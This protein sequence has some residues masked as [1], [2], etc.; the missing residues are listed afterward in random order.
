MDNKFQRTALLLG[1]DGVEKLSK[2][3][4]AVFGLGGV[5]GYAVEALA[6]S[7]IGELD[8][9][10]C[11][12][13]SESNINRQIIATVKSIGQKKTDAAAERVLSINPNIKVRSHFIEFLPKTSENFEFKK[14]DYIIDAID[15]VTGKIELVLKAD[16]YGVPIISSM[17]TGNK[18]DPSAFKIADIYDTSVC[19][20]ARVM[21]RELKKRNIKALKVV[22]SEE[23]P[24][25]CPNAEP[26]NEFSRRPIPGSVSFVPPA[27][28]LIIAGE[29]IK[30][31][32][33]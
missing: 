2:K 10:D 16:E 31:L 32:I 14:Y 17:G 6:R 25:S 27:A 20:L 1:E 13:V 18:L 8:L 23:T 21:R 33:K 24:I 29:V 26:A 22:Y 30:D 19:P 7:G 28:G 9:I 11:D 15:S 5:G 12:V 3:R 4:V